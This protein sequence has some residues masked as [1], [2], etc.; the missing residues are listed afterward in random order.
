MSRP[1]FEEDS[2][3]IQVRNVTVEPPC[4]TCFR[5][6]SLFIVR[7]VRYINALCRYMQSS[8]IEKQVVYIVTIVFYRVKVLASRV[9]D[10]CC[11]HY[12]VPEVT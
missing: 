1:G 6:Q 5:K 3:R 4:S 10:C 7:I 8:E 12:A 11:Y 9:L 2:S